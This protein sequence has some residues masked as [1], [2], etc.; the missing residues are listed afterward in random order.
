MKAVVANAYGPI[1]SLVI[2][3]LPM[4][5]PGPGQVRIK[6]L[7]AG[8]NPFDFKLVEGGLKALYPVRHPWVPGHDVCGTV[9]AVG[10]GAR[11]LVAPGQRVY[12]LSHLKA[13]KGKPSAGA[14]AEFVLM[15]ASDV[16]PAPVGLSDTDVAA[17]PMCLTTAVRGL[18]T[19]GRMKAGNRVL[20]NGASG[21]V[22]HLAVQVAKAL[23]ATV[24]A[25][26]S[27][28][29]MDFVKGLGADEVIDY[30]ATDVS[31][32]GER[33]D[34]VFDAVASLSYGKA[35]RLL[36][37]DGAYVTTLPNFE[38]IIRSLLGPLLSSR[39]CPLLAVG[40]ADE[41][42]KFAAALLDTGRVKPHVQRVYPMREAVAALT[43]LSKG[44]VVGK[45]V[46]V[47]E[48]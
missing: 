17:L 11:H 18:R 4:P 12:G 42:L 31:K 40:K 15:P 27:A 26:C 37:P 39:R 2:G 19:E 24:T 8:I 5:E 9:D 1:D 16:L 28:A 7:A 44:R 35:A 33:F 22:G 34:L 13:A 29:N 41:H 32:L 43:E 47:P 25:T 48:W 46:L 45:L 20:V 21:G 3:E 6:V 14:L 36:I 10:A 23:G 30:R 38:V